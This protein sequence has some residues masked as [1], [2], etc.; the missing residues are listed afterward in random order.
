MEGVGINFIA[1]GHLFSHNLLSFFNA[2]HLIFIFFIGNLVLTRLLI[3]I[4]DKIPAYG[5]DSFNP[6]N[7]INNTLR[8]T[9]RR[10]R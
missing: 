3:D 1:L 4:L 9:A 2:S 8:P 6:N 10:L 7:L 5:T